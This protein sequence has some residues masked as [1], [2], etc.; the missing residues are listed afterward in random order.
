[1]T[2]LFHLAIRYPDRAS[3]V[4]A[5]CRLS[6]AGWPI[7]SAVDHGTHEAIYVDDPDHNGLELCW[8]RP[9]SEWPLEPDGRLSSFYQSLDLAVILKTK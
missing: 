2:G 9:E 8:D 7:D 3:F 5:I 1:M 4:D 6:D